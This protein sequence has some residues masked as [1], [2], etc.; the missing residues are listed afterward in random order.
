M[1][2]NL[3]GS[4]TAGG[5]EP[6]LKGDAFTTQYERLI[7]EIRAGQWSGALDST[8]PRDARS[9][10][11][12]AAENGM[13]ELT[14]AVLEFG[15]SPDG[16]GDSAAIAA[17]TYGHIEILRALAEAGVAVEKTS[18]RKNSPLS[19][20]CRYGHLEIVRF[21]LARGADP[22]AGDSSGHGFKM[23]DLA[24]GVHRSEIIAALE[25]ARSGDAEGLQAAA[26][27]L[28]PES[29]STA[30]PGE[31]VETEWD[32][33]GETMLSVRLG[34]PPTAGNP[35]LLSIAL[36]N[37][38]GPL[39]GAQVEVCVASTEDDVSDEAWKPAELKE[40]VLFIEDDEV[41]RAQVTERLTDETPWEA[42]FEAAVKLID[43]LNFIHLRVRNAPFEE[44]NKVALEPWAVAVP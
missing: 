23:D 29:I 41:P 31:T 18:K 43:G 2:R 32:L 6:E 26:R 37:L 16:A 30:G 7:D 20:A 34:T 33:P 10:L 35:A 1:L 17:A 9:V 28:P 11:E 24:G 8:D 27:D 4:I 12:F 42:R 25:I 14:R 21:L 5:R 13:V 39:D 19:E 38:Y 3:L 44:L 36:N 22:N 40:A 15:A